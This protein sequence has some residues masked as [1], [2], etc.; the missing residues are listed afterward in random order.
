MQGCLLWVKMSI[1]GCTQELS[2]RLDALIA[3]KPSNASGFTAI[4]DPHCVQK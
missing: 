3:F 2:L 4:D 1:V